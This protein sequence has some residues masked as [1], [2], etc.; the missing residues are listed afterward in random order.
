M[1]NEKSC[2]AVVFKFEDGELYFLI[3]HM[4][5]GH[6]SI[7][8][9]HV[10][11]NETEEET[12]LREIREETGLRVHLITAF[13]HSVTYSPYPDVEK[14]VVFFVAQPIDGELKNQEEEVCLLEWLPC[15]QAIEA[16][17]YESVREV[18]K[19]ATEWLRDKK[20]AVGY[21]LISKRE[22][23][24][25]TAPRQIAEEMGMKFVHNTYQQFNWRYRHWLEAFP[26][27]PEDYYDSFPDDEIFESYYQEYCQ[28][29]WKLESP[30]DVKLAFICEC[31]Y[32]YAVEHEDEMDD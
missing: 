16:V 11:G 28:D 32:H 12:A 1:K 26:L 13:R 14:E 15:E 27:K 17:T 22:Y 20:N 6:V 31:A 30:E 21:S 10:E 29:T 19:H 23:L 18:L 24:L 8:K 4:V 5:K 2:G 7:P 3:E 25:T 9:G